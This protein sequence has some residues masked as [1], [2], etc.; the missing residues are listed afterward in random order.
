[1]KSFDFAQY[2]GQLDRR[3]PY[4]NIS[5]TPWYP[6]ATYAKFSDAEFERRYRITREKMARLGVRR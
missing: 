2:H 1:M 3:E 6:G 5:G 4:G